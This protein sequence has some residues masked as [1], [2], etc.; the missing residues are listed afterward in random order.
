LNLLKKLGIKSITAHGLAAK[1]NMS[2]R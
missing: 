1:V 2:V